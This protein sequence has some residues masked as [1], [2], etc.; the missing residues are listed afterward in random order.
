MKNW[1]HPRYFNLYGPTETNVCTY[2]EVTRPLP[3]TAPKP[4]P[5]GKVCSHLESVVVDLDGAV[6]KGERVNC[7]FAAPGSRLATGT[8]GAA[9]NAF[10]AVG[11]GPAYYRTGDIVS[12]EADGNSDI[13][14]AATG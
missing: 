9:R 8:S 4:M 7:A 6:T 3:R 11:A 1:P 5:I 10:I 2:Y 12:E 14:A 13:S